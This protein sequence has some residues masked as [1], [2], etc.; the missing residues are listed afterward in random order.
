MFTLVR[1][2]ILYNLYIFHRAYKGVK[3]NA[4]QMHAN[5]PKIL[6]RPTFYQLAITALALFPLTILEFESTKVRQL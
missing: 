5:K 2:R 6:P 3:L 1:L 4:N